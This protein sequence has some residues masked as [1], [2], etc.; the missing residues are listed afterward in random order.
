MIG[1]RG[2]PKAKYKKPDLK[3]KSLHTRR[4]S[5]ARNFGC[6]YIH[7]RQRNGDK[8]WY[9][10]PE[11]FLYDREDK[12]VCDLLNEIYHAARNLRGYFSQNSDHRA[13]VL[14]LTPGRRMHNLLQGLVVMRLKDFKEYFIGEQKEPEL[15]PINFLEW[16]FAAN[17]DLIDS[18]KK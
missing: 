13:I 16:T 15:E 17:A 4:K 2:R 18:T 1:N 6:K 10:H 14:Y 11:W 9:N 8:I 7:P 12:T 5:I 3:D